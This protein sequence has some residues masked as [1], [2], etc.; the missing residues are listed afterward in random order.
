MHLCIITW[1]YINAKQFLKKFR[2]EEVS[3]TTMSVVDFNGQNSIFSQKKKQM[4]E[5][6]RKELPYTF[7]GNISIT[8]QL[9]CFS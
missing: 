8:A 9:R 5:Q 6:A 2:N 4:M 7:K 1:V 3:Y